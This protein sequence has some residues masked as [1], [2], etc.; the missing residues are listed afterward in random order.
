MCD[1]SLSTIS[2]GHT[3][4]SYFT[5]IIKCDN[6]LFKASF[7]NTSFSS[8]LQMGQISYTRPEMFASYKHSYLLGTFVMYEKNEVLWIRPQVL[9]RKLSLINRDIRMINMTHT[10]CRNKFSSKKV[11]TLLR[12]PDKTYRHKDIRI[13]TLVMSCS[14]PKICLPC[15]WIKMF[16]FMYANHL[17]MLVQTQ[18]YWHLESVPTLQT[19]SP[20]RLVKSTMGSVD[21][22]IRFLVVVSGVKCE[23]PC[24][25][26]HR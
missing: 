5:V 1:P 2:R 8:N 6:S 14:R 24:K 19:A 26:I 17:S 22:S 21:F 3:D 16:N 11:V 18:L 10:W 20:P 4:M 15:K 25:S 23:S 13:D 7:H 9:S 12:R